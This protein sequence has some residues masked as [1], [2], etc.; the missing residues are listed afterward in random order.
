M[1]K[2]IGNWELAPV[3]SNGGICKMVLECTAFKDFIGL[4]SDLSIL[5]SGAALHGC[6]TF[7]YECCS[8]PFTPRV[9]IS[10]ADNPDTPNTLAQ[11]LE[12]M[13]LI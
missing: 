4:A 10:F 2:L 9:V 5:I 3:L 6:T 11:F 1:E 12:W 13:T 8:S 7:I